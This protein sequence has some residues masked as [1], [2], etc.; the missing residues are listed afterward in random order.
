MNDF[1]NGIYQ[2]L[3]ERF[4]PEEIGQFLGNFLSD[5]LVGIFIFFVFYGLW[6]VAKIVLRVIVK[7][8]NIDKTTASFISISLRFALLTLGVIQALSAV[9]INTAALLT[10]LGIVSLTI[11][12]AAR[13]ALSNLIS[14]ILIFWDRPFVI[15]DLIELEGGR[16]GRVDRITLRSTRVVTVDGKMLAIPNTEII[17][18]TVSSYTN[19]PNIRLGIDITIAVNEDIDLSRKIMMGLVAEDTDFLKTPPPRVVVTGLNDYNIALQ[20]QVWL[21]D[22]RQHI[23]KSFVLREAIYKALNKAGVDMPYETIQVVPLESMLPES[24]K[25]PAA[26]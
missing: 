5:L 15:G 22:E 26:S 20:L 25:S 12:F 2:R 23:T 4:D 21:E 8:A 1:V 7:G 18:S 14:G 9:G 19:F 16:Y 11:G 13:D 17:N 6:R 24:K 3:G 10:S